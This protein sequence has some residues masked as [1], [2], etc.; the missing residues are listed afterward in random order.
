MDQE[1]AHTIDEIR[2]FE[3][4]SEEEANNEADKQPPTKRLRKD[5][6]DAWQHDA[7]AADDGLVTGG[8]ASRASVAN[9]GP[10]KMSIT[11]ATG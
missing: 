5:P 6:A 9:F 3:N 7:A 8:P 11:L 2:R 4:D 10:E 1:D